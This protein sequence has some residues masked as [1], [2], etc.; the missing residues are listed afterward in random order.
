MT[1]RTRVRLWLTLGAIPF[2]LCAILLGVKLMSLQLVTADAI[3]DFDAGD[4]ASSEAQFGSLVDNS[5]VET[6]IPF[7]DRGDAKVGADDL[8]SAIDD[9]ED[10]LHLAPIERRC[11]I[12]LNL[13][14]TWESL[15]DE[16]EASGSHQGAVKLYENA[17]KVLDGVSD[18]CETSGQ[19][20]ERDGQ[21]Q[22]ERAKQDAAARARDA[23]EQNDGGVTPDDRLGELGDK[24]SQSDQ[25]KQNGESRG[26][27]PLGGLGGDGSDTP[28]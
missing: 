15:G 5:L 28:W 2:A 23:Q 13:A 20:Q 19:E 9:F 17:Q 1:R 24:Q 3:S 18:A 11:M 22:R 16:Y 21:Q 14:A 8:T 27:A 10:A 12:A 6:W 7:F 26:R 4:Y 25:D